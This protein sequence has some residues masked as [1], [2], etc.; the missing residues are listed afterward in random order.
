M[1]IFKCLS[2]RPKKKKKTNWEL[3]QRI[4]C[5]LFRLEAFYWVVKVEIRRNDGEFEK[6][7]F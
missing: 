4:I 2:E 7:I 6:K 1:V 5:F 3:F